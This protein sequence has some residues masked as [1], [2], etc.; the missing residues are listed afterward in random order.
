M[1][2]RVGGKFKIC[3]KLGK[4]AFGEIYQGQNLKTGEEV[5]IKLEKTDT[6]SPMLLY[7]ANLYKRMGG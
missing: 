2:I 5:A 7:E 6:D 1:E 4:G 3:K